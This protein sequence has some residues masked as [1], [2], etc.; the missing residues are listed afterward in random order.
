ME[1]TR[2]EIS[3]RALGL[4]NPWKHSRVNYSRRYKNIGEEKN[5][6]AYVIKVIIKI[7][8]VAPFLRRNIIQQDQIRRWLFER[9]SGVCV[10]LNQLPVLR[11][12]PNIKLNHKKKGS[13]VNATNKKMSLHHIVKNAFWMHNEFHNKKQRARMKPYS[14]LRLQDVTINSPH[15]VKCKKDQKINIF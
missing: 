3:W 2:A 6:L 13:Y 11:C 8:N 5:L 1:T 9:E 4:A 14:G 15:I 12:I 7:Y 10:W